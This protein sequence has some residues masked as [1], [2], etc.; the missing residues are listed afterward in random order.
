MEIEGLGWLASGGETGGFGS[1]V[2][3][4]GWV[5]SMRESERERERERERLYI[6]SFLGF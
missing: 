6:L 1:L 2:L 3:G 5:S 4:A